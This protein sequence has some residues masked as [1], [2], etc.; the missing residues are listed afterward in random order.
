MQFLKRHWEIIL[1]FLIACVFRLS[2]IHNNEIGFWYDQ[3]RDAHLSQE[4]FLEKDLKIQ[5]PSAS[6]SQDIFFHGVLYYYLIGAWYIIGGGSPLFVSSLLAITGSLAVFVVYALAKTLKQPKAVGLLA[7]ALIATSYLHTQL[8]IWLS[9]PQLLAITV[10]LFYFFLWKVFS[11][12]AKIRDFALLGIFCGLSVQFALYEIFLGF[13][14]VAMYCL[15]SF[16]LKKIFIF[17]WQE[18]LTAAVTFF[19]TISSM[20]LAEAIMFKRGILTLDSLDALGSGDMLLSEKIT[21][22]SEMYQKFLQTSLAPDSPFFVT[23]VLTIP[24]IF[25]IWQAR[26]KLQFWI[27]LYL[28]APASLLV[29]LFKDSTHVL[30]GVEFVLYFSWAMGAVALAQKSRLFKAVI[31]VAVVSIVSLNGMQVWEQRLEKKQYFVI[32]K[33]AMLQDQINLIDEMYRASNGNE[34]SFSASTNPFGINITWI[35][36]LQWY[37]L[38]KYGYTPFFFGPDQAGLY[39]EDILT[40]TSSAMPQHFTVLEPGTGL[41]AGHLADFLSNQDRDAGTPSAEQKFGSLILQVRD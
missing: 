36:L 14:V 26:K 11:Q 30:G 28:L 3:A 37:A 8:S 18:Y 20:I 17:R 12:S 10:P 15:Q 4:I 22:T 2:V 25:G 5:G 40:A 41:S 16:K 9:N 24:I 32:Q 23:L 31:A 19:A 21:K 33:E 6:G 39:G 34:F 35:Y 1:I 27:L 29:V 38:P 7:A 13:S